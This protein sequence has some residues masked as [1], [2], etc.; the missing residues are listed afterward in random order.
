VALYDLGL[1][2]EQVRGGEMIAAVF[3]AA[4]I[5]VDYFGKKLGKVK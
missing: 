1:S 5:A 4:L 3:I 2:C